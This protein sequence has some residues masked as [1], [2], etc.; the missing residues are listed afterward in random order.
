MTASLALIGAGL[1]LGAVFLGRIR[2]P[3]GGP[4]P[5]SVSLIIPARDEAATLPDLLASLRSQQ[6]AELIVVDHGSTDGTA[7]VARQGG[8]TVVHAPPLP[9]GWVG[10]PWACHLGSL[11]ATG[12]VLVFADAD[13][14]FAPGGLDRV[15]G[16]WAAE[17]P[18]GL[19][20]IQ[21]FHRTE[22]ASEQLSAYPNLVAMMASGAFVVGRTRAT[23][24]AFG[25]CLVTAADT[26]RSL[27]G[28]EAVADEVIE[29]V[30]LG[31]AYGAAGRP[32]RTLAGGSAVSF[33]MY[34]GGLRPLVDGWTKNLSGGPRLASPLPVAAA[35]AWICAS[36]AVAM[37]AAAALGA[38]ATT[39][40]V[41]WG[42]VIGWVLVGAQLTW[43][44]RR[45]GRFAWWAGPAWPVLLASFVLLFVRS[46]ALRTIRRRVTWHGRSIAVRVR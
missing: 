43:L 2:E 6:P 24:A 41:R 18:D 15:V 5:G 13:V 8:A 34:P 10:K 28:H 23:P 4:V 39:G 27:G 19:L 35:V 33:R 3:G 26:Y 17:V 32:V 9:E 42:A 29:D 36:V 12:E 7:D 37:E 44:L 16:A 46:A 45:I 30:H 40:E 22:R 14:R 20:S 21:P 38:A 1:V 11:H 25:P 31:R